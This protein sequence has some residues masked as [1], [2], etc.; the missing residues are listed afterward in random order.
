MTNNNN[1]KNQSSHFPFVISNKQWIEMS[2]ELKEEGEKTLSPNSIFIFRSIEILF[3]V[4]LLTTSK[5]STKLSAIWLICCWMDLINFHCIEIYILFTVIDCIICIPK[6]DEIWKLIVF[7]PVIE[8]FLFLYS[9]EEV[10]QKSTSWYSLCQPA[11]I[12]E[13]KCIH[14]LIS[15]VNFRNS[16]FDQLQTVSNSFHKQQHPET[17]KQLEKCLRFECQ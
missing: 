2:F 1:N 16:S 10:S 9:S 3:W 7:D 14:R 8:I 6:I 17:S 13:P 15:N 5:C 11:K 4:K 12:S